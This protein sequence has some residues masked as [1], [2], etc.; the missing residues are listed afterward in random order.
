METILNWGD[1]TMQAFMRMGEQL[2]GGITNLIGAILVL[3]LGWLFTKL[4]V[5]VLGKLL[6]AS[7]IDR[8]KD[9][10]NESNIFGDTN[11]KFEPSTVILV[12]VRWILYLV[13]IIVAADIMNWTIISN[14]ITNVLAYL[15]KLFIAIALFVVGLYIANFIRKALRGLFDSLALTGAQVISSI[16]FYIIVILFTVTALNQA[17]IDTSLITG[18]IMII[19]AGLILTLSIALGIG[20][21]EVVQKILLTYYM[22][23]GLSVG[24]QVKFEDVSGVVSSIDNLSITISTADKK[25]VIIP[26]KEMANKKVEVSEKKNN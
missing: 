26:V 22:R 2:S 4:V 20:S 21:I 25:K 17:S 24:D 11:I 19:I 9:K 7:R 3:I 15:P 12:F 18:N 23:K 6:K 8:L 13:F 1:V 5:F 10:V 14:E 16:V